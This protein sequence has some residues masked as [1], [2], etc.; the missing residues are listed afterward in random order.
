M[1]SECSV[2]PAKIKL[3]FKSELFSLEGNDLEIEDE[4]E[5]SFFADINQGE[6]DDIDIGQDWYGL[7]FTGIK[8]KIS[9]SQT[10]MKK[11]EILSAKIKKSN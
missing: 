10:Q 2:N 11:V 6:D 7:P 8:P 9:L 3:Q 1:E 5:A 4:E